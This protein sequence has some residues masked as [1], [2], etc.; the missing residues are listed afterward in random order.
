[1][2][3]RQNAMAKIVR[4][5]VVSFLFAGGMA[6]MPVQADASAATPPQVTSSALGNPAETPG[7]LAFGRSSWETP[8]WVVSTG[9]S[10]SC[11]QQR[12]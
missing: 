4:A 6:F 10:G 12:I 1:M 8:F 2:Q 3:Q 5:T 11:E 9:A 7:R